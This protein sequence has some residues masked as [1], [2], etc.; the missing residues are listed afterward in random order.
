MTSVK[1]IGDMLCQHGLTLGTVESAT[2]GL[3]AH[4]MTNVPG[5]SACYKGS[6]VAYSNQVKMRLAGVS[7]ETI[8]AYGAV[9][10]QVAEEMAVGGRRALGVSICLSDTGIAG[11][12]GATATKPVGL[13]YISLAYEGG[14]FSRKHVFHGDRE[15]NKMAAA[16]AAFWMLQEY[17][18]G[19]SMVG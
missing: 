9:S 13:F 10:P 15:Q 2:G 17:L 12:G 7:E 16:Q 18:A 19:I 5:S 3:I 14:V 8:N 6:I 1:E 4:L 11:P